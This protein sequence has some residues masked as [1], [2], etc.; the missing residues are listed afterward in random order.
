MIFPRMNDMSKSELRASKLQSHVQALRDKF[1]M[2]V[3]VG[4][5]TS[6]GFTFYPEWPARLWRDRE[7]MREAQEEV[8]IGQ[9][10][11]SLDQRTTD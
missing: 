1:K 11:E 3:S 9:T 10:R 6:A 4:W 7:T 2:R 8:K 5:Q